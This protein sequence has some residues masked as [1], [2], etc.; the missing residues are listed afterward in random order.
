MKMGRKMTRLKKKRTSGYRARM[1]TKAGK[2]LFKRRRAK[3]C[4]ELGK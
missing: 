4:N 1:K 3:G 2:R